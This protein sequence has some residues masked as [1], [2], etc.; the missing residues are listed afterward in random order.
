MAV[1]RC[2]T[3]FVVWPVA[4]HGARTVVQVFKSSSA[5]YFLAVTCKLFFLVLAL[6]LFPSA[7]SAQQS[8]NA[9]V[10]AVRIL[11]QYRETQIPLWMSD[12]GNLARYR[13]ANAK[14]SPPM[15]DESRVV[16]MGDS[17]TDSW[18][19]A[20][21]FPGKPYVN[22]GIS[23]QT[24]RQMLLRFRPD[25]IELQPKVVVILAGTNDIA[26]NTGP[27]TLDEIT[28]NIE[29]MAELARFHGMRVVLCSVTPVSD[30]PERSKVYFPLR[31]PDEIVELNRRIKDYCAKSGC[32][33]LDYFSAMVDA[34]GLMKPELADDGLHPNARG[35]AVMVPMAEKAIAEALGR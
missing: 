8:S 35:Y 7:A 5:C 21:C 22:R 12:Y 32:V 17:I 25:V 24:T 4:T 30:Y 27:M 14:V 19:L 15:A 33:Y 6:S 26:G 31:P 23:G 28:A 1:E 34:K 10:E 3:A 11:E 2:F 13:E 9:A 16:F 29:S 20:K 18:D